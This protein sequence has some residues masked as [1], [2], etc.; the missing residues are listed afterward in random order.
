MPCLCSNLIFYVQDGS[1]IVPSYLES[2]SQVHSMTSQLDSSLGID[3][4]MDP[5]MDPSLE[6]SL[7]QDEE[8]QYDDG[9]ED[10]ID[11]GVDDSEQGMEV[12]HITGRRCKGVA[13]LSS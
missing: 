12:L 2:G 1:L 4:S 7:Q 10:G 13:L 5:D 9:I 11:Q 3:P 6:R 8:D